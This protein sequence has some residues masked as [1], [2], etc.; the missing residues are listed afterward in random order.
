MFFKWCVAKIRWH[1]PSQRVLAVARL[2][3]SAAGQAVA[4]LNAAASRALDAPVVNERFREIGLV[5]AEIRNWAGPIRKAG[6]VED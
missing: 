3:K 4:R 6:V 1:G 2:P 5:A